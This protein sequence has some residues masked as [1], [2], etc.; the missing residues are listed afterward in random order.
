MMM[1]IA[2]V[3]AVGLLAGSGRGDEKQNAGSVT[4]GKD[5]PKATAAGVE[6]K[7]EFKVSD[8][9]TIKEAW[10]LTVPKK[11]GVA[12]EKTKLAFTDGA[13][14]GDAKGKIVPAEAKTG[15]GEWNVLVRFVFEKKLPNGTVQT[16]EWQAS[17]K[18]VEVK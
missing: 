11:G 18:S 7:G 8:G 4:W 17:T 9:W 5:Y 13:W 6:L 2:C 1:R 16:A 10:F 3:V 15:K 14:G 12:S